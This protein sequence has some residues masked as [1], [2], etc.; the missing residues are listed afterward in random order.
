MNISN[1]ISENQEY[2]NKI[3][4]TD[5]FYYVTDNFV[6]IRADNDG[7]IKGF[8][9]DKE[10]TDKF[11]ALLEEAERDTCSNV[12][13]PI[14]NFLMPSQTTCKECR[15]SG[16]LV[17]CDECDG[18]GTIILGY[19]GKYDDYSTEEDCKHCNGTGELPSDSSNDK[20]Y[21][22]DGCHGLGMSYGDA[23]SKYK[24]I[25]LSPYLIIK[26]LENLEDIIF[27]ISED[28]LDN[29]YTKL[30]FEHKTGKGCCMQAV[31]EEK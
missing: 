3:Y 12:K 22:C 30:Y 11:E 7:T 16:L 20:A 25:R 27:Y 26:L 1:F 14:S 6:L 5:E 21:I 10:I 28:M 4:A 9:K 31:R 29:V 2:Y 15:G 13:V 17:E 18:S 23:L 24:N 8:K 19:D